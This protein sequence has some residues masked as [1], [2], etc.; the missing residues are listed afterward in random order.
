MFT[1]RT[2]DD[3]VKD[4]KGRTIART[5]K[6][7]FFKSSQR[8]TNL[9]RKMNKALITRLNRRYGVYD[10][11]DLKCLLN[12]CAS[13][14]KKKIDSAIKKQIKINNNLHERLK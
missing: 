3:S 8:S 14:D 4:N 6:N 12:N 9:K 1:V 7:L 11:T 13:G 10:V 2:G 5:N